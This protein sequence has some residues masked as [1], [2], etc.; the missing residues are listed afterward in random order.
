MLG[1]MSLNAAYEYFMELCTLP[2]TVANKH[3]QTPYL[4]VVAVK[5]R[6]RVKIKCMGKTKDTPHCRK[7]IN[8]VFYSLSISTTINK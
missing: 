7:N 3:P 2:D 1:I 4:A 8:A 5:R 6:D